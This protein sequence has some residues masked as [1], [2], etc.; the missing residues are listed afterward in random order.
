MNLV[1][2]VTTADIDPSWLLRIFT[3]I[4]VVLILL[5]GAGSLWIY[6]FVLSLLPQGQ[7]MV[8]LSGLVKDV[9]VV[10]DNN[11]VPGIVGEREDDV[12]MVLGYVMA[13]DRLWQ[14]DFLR[15]AG[16]GRL[17]EILGPDYLRGDEIIRTVRAGKQV[18]D[19]LK[20]MEPTERKWLD[21][22]VRGINQYIVSH[23][24]KLPVEFSL[25]EYRPRSFTADDVASIVTALTWESSQA[26]R[27][28]PLM[29]RILGRLGS[30]KALEFFPTD[31]SAS[32]A[33]VTSDL[34][35]W[36]PRG[37]L[38]NPPGP[39]RRSVPGLWG[40]CAWAVGPDRTRSGKPMTACSVY[41]ALSAPGFW[42]RARL[43]ASGFH[44]SGAFIP[45]V[46][47]ALAGSNEKVTFG[48]VPLAADDADLYIERLDSDEAETYWRV[49]RRKR[50]EVV[51]E[52]FRVRGGPSVTRL[53]R[54]TDTGPLVSDVNKG[55]ALSL[56]WT[57]REGLGFLST[58][59][60]LNRSR[61]P[62]DVQKALKG[63]VAP[64]MSVVWSD[65]QGNFGSQSAGK[66]PVRPPGS[67]GIVPLPAWTGVHDWMGYIPFDDLPKAL[68]PRDGFCVAADGRPGGPHYPYF[69]GCY[70]SVDAREERISHL[71]KKSREHFRESLQE[72]QSDSFSPAARDLVPR[73]LA[74]V[75][76]QARKNRAEETAIR[77]LSS[78]DCRMQD[79]SSGAAVFAL[80]YKSLMEDLLA[81]PL[82]ADLYADYVANPILTSQFM[83]KVLGDKKVVQNSGIN[84]EKLLCEGFR[85]GIT[86]GKGLMGDD[87]AKWK[88]G[89]IHRVSFRHPLATRSRFL[90]ALYDV[91]PLSLPGSF[92][93]INFA[94]WSPAQAFGVGAGVSLRQVSDMTEPPQIY[95][96]SP[97]GASAHFFSAHYK[98][99]T[100]SWVK[101]RSFRE[102]IQTVDIRKSGFDPVLF[103][104][105][106]GGTISKNEPSHLSIY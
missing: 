98:D 86:L 62:E 31:D 54:L 38:F 99:Q 7:S 41:Q 85:N 33:L 10:R 12:A 17:A 19:G 27:I 101:G 53:V 26:V 105:G 11:G 95:A 3:I 44:L 70:W 90:E 76:K 63:L 102:P 32:K 88:W 73:M 5:A 46:P 51:R 39:V 30:E 75:G 97:L 28:D 69:S 80:T 64:C 94:G 92:D 16:Q 9:R 34:N 48:T 60:A 15:R 1:K 87:P 49:D 67:D 50:M 29:T 78:W 6:F 57:A 8:Q 14:M 82:G 84:E 59:H 79:D 43:V 106:S 68:N 56:R 61:G 36:Q 65:D 35:G 66:I 4:P 81:R 104:A 25:L 21:S 74:A 100:G 77:V 20:D 89:E 37:L 2:T 40:G 93:T 96:A 55:L 52:T 13:Q 47:V 24:G 91:G 72:I 45:G 22:F 83:K 18:R 103:K 58:F 71:V 23:E 42:Y